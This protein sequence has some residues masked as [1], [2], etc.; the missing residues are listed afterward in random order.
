MLPMN[1]HGNWFRRKK[2]LEAYI[3]GVRCKVIAIDHRVS[4]NYPSI[5]AKRYGVKMRNRRHK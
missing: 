3:N 1:N 5:L 2:I 4:P